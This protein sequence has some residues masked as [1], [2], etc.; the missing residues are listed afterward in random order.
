MYPWG[1]YCIMPTST[2]LTIVK[3]LPVKKMIIMQYLFQKYRRLQMEGNQTLKLIIVFSALLL[4]SCQAM[5]KTDS[6]PLPDSS[7]SVKLNAEERPAAFAAEVRYANKYVADTMFANINGQEIIITKNGRAYK[8]GALYFN[9]KCKDY[10]EKL[11]FY[12]VD[13][14]IIAFYVDSNGDESVSIAKRINPGKNKIVW[15]TPLYGFNMAKPLIVDNK[16]YISTIGFIGKLNLS[17]GKFEWK[18]DGLY[19]DGKYNSFGTPEFYENGLVMFKSFDAVT[20]QT[21]SILIDDKRGKIV[22][23]D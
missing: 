15:E 18:F 2:E 4:V 9:L 6:T 17:T 21:N 14:D 22:K 3:Y 20:K 16:A 1:R 8:R 11:F 5:K 10:I 7:S 12:N 13:N 23:K 19:R